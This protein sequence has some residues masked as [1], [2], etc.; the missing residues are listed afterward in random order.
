LGSG[1]GIPCEN[2][3]GLEHEISKYTRLIIG[4]ILEILSFANIMIYYSIISKANQIGD[5]K[6]GLGDP[7]KALA[8][9]SDAFKYQLIASI[10][11]AGFF[12][13]LFRKPIYIQIFFS[14]VIG[15]TTFCVLWMWSFSI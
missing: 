7:V 14:I 10:L 11:M 5:T 4:S 1:V 9:E 2:N 6:A 12:A 13:Y 3:S 15:L 8:I